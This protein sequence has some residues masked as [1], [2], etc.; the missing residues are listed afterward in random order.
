MAVMVIILAL[1][2]ML[3]ELLRMT[4][5]ITAY[6]KD[7]RNCI[8]ILLYT[9]CI[10]FVFNFANSCGCV[11][12]WQWQLGIFV[13]FLAWI[14]LVFFASKF[15]LTGI[16]VLVFKEILITFLKLTVFSILLVLAFSL[17]LYMM[18][19]DPNAM[20]SIV[21]NYNILIKII[22]SQPCYSSL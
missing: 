20:V 22:I 18:F 6:L 19:S 4:Y 16:Y 12:D 21:S 13:V 1:Y 7:V 15:P 14:N 17:I 3:V 10:V 9:T 5:S 11:L 8:E 2:H